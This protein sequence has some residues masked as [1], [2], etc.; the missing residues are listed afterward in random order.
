MDENLSVLRTIVWGMVDEPNYDLR[1]A[2][3]KEMAAYNLWVT[4]AF[5]P[6]IEGS[7]Q[8]QYRLTKLRIRHPRKRRSRIARHRGGPHGYAV[9][10]FK[11]CC[12][13]AMRR[14]DPETYA[15]APDLN[16]DIWFNLL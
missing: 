9:G 10:S 5:A 14:I 2:A 11:H 7:N 15:A 16:H 3:R 4:G 1:R 12:L 8:G 13:A 6:G